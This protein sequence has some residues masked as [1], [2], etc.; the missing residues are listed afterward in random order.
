[1]IKTE[2]DNIPV[3]DIER[4]RRWALEE[5]S[6]FHQRARRFFSKLDRDFTARGANSPRR[7]RVSLG[8]FSIT[9]VVN[10]D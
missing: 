6:A 8:S 2:Y 3:K 4:A 7:V 9:E 10:E 5:G 1:H